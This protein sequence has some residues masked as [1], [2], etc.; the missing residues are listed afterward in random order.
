MRVL[1]VKAFLP[2]SVFASMKSAKRPKGTRRV[3]SRG[4]AFCKSSDCPV[5]PTCWSGAN[6]RKA[7]GDFP[8]IGAPALR[9][10]HGVK[11]TKLADLAAWTQDDL[12]ELHGM[13]PVA[14]KR[15]RAALSAKGMQFKK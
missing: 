12:L 3:C 14:I 10:L 4:H 2:L 11:V 13:G 1:I 7:L 15:L 9:A 5:C 6:K 8:N